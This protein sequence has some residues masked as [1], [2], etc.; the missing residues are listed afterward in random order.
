MTHDNCDTTGRL[1]RCSDG[2]AARTRRCGENGPRRE[3]PDSGMRHNGEPCQ[4]S[5]GASGGRGIGRSLLGPLL[6]V[7]LWGSF[8]LT[9][10]VIGIRV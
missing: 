10:M 4:L 8:F 6:W 5:G 7:I 1:P 9:V 2:S 3:R